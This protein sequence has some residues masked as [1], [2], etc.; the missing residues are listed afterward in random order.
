MGNLKVVKIKD[1][2]KALLKRNNRKYHDLAKHLD[3]SLSTVK[4]ILGAEELTIARLIKICEY[5]NVSL[6]ELESFCESNSKDTSK[7]TP[8]QEKFLS[9]NKEYFSYLYRL[10][11]GLTPTDIAKRYNLTKLSTD[12]YLITLEKM[13]LIKVTASGKIK[14]RVNYSTKWQHGFLNKEYYSDIQDK[15]SHFFKERFNHMDSLSSESLDNSLKN[16]YPDSTNLNVFRLT[17][18]S[19]LKWVKENAKS[20]QELKQISEIESKTLDISKLVTVVAQSNFTCVDYYYKGLGI[21]RD[22]FGEIKNLD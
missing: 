11:S 14:A 9:E 3:C 2:I 21:F 17:H 13:E 16:V 18:D 19:Y 7:F 10:N 15:F 6:A 20:Y 22:I 5:L 8:K 12:K 1:G 4:R